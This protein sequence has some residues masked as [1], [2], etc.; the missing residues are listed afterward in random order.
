MKTIYV[1]SG[2]I[3]LAAVIGLARNVIR[4]KSMDQTGRV[5]CGLRI[6]MWMVMLYWAAMA[7]W[8]VYSRGDTDAAGPHIVWLAIAQWPA[9]LI[10]TVE[11]GKRRRS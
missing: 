5:M 2:V 1:V 11:Y 10:D 9:I 3:T 7:A 6:C 8:R 4:F